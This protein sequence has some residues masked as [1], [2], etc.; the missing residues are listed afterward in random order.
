[1][2]V[3]RRGFG[4]HAGDFQDGGALAVQPDRLAINNQA[5]HIA[6]DALLRVEGVE[7][8]HGERQLLAAHHQ[9]DRTAT[10]PSCDSA[11]DQDIKV[12]PNRHLG[13]TELSGRRRH[14]D[15]AMQ[16]QC[17]DELVDPCCRVHGSE[18]TS[19]MFVRTKTMC[20]RLPP[21]IRPDNPAFRRS[22][23]RRCPVAE[24]AGAPSTTGAGRARARRGS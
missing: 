18:L 19:S 2:A 3:S 1:M 9:V 12:S 16:S 6:G 24:Y 13:G 4:Q 21:L 8:P 17:L 20:V 11:L 15:P 22:P 14:V 23:D 7:L 10:Y 5:R